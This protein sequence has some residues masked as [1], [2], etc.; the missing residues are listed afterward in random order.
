MKTV[1]EFGKDLEPDL[2]VMAGRLILGG[3]NGEELAKHSLDRENS[4]PSHT[5]LLNGG[6]QNRL[7]RVD[8]IVIRKSCI[9]SQ[10]ILKAVDGFLETAKMPRL[11]IV[12][13]GW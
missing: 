2:F 12:S 11:N 7:G 10:E 3:N 1:F 13:V 4:L 5:H 6:I 9:L 8:L